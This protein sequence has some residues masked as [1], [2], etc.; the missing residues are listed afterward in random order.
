ML[1]FFFVLFVAAVTP[2][3]NRCSKAG[4]AYPHAPCIANNA[5]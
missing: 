5:L 1:P 3:T 4:R 2:L